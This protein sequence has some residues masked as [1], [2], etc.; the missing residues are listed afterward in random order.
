MT[1][2]LMIV[3][4][5]SKGCMVQNGLV[6]I[7]VVVVYGTYLL[8]VIHQTIQMALLIQLLLKL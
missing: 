8:I 4:V 6:A 3:T 5:A 2:L 7:V 1:L